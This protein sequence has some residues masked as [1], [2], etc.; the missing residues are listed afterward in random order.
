MKLRA[1][2]HR[3]YYFNIGLKSLEGVNNFCAT[4]SDTIFVVNLNQWSLKDVVLSQCLESPDTGRIFL[5]SAS[6]YMPLANYYQMK[7]KN[8]IAICQ[9]GNSIKVL[10]KLLSNKFVAHT[11]ISYQHPHLSER[12]F[13]SLYYLFNG[14]NAHKQASSMGLCAKTVYTFR[15][16][17]AVKLQVKK[18]SHLL[19]PSYRDFK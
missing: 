15:D 18:L 16:K 4:D 5:I 13:I 12:E 7:N 14:V 9:E 8:I 17:L 6:Q 2:P 11:E 19:L 3:N 10:R 1:F